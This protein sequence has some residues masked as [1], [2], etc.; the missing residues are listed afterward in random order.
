MV[1]VR[2]G[3]MVGVEKGGMAGVEEGGML[4][5]VP[6]YYAGYM[7]PYYAGYVPTLHTLV[8]MPPCY[9]GYTTIPLRHAGVLRCSVWCGGERPWGSE[10]L[11][12]MGE[13]KRGGS[14]S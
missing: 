14:C 10:R 11:K 8:Y 6:L 1:G 12:P 9:P 4:G 3:G 7:P 13:K 2:E 5:G